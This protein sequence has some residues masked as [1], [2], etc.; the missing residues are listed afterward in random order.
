[1]DNQGNNWTNNQI[2]L[3][4][5]DILNLDPNNYRF[6]DSDNYKSVPESDITSLDVQ[7]RTYKQVIGKNAENIRDLIDSF[8]INGYL[9]VDQIQVKKL[10]NN[11]YLVVEGNRRVAC[12]KYL[13]SKSESEGYDLGRLDK[14]IFS[15]LPVIHY[16]DAADVHHL[17]LMGLKHISGNKKWP[18]INQAEL[19]RT[20][21]THY[22][23]KEDDICHSIGIQ[24]TE[25]NRII[26]TLALIDEYKKSDYGEQF[27][28]EKYS[29]FN[30][31]I[32]SQPIKNW[33]KWNDELRI[34]E[35]KNNLQ[36]LFS[37]ISEEVND[38][39]EDDEE[40]II[41]NNPRYK[42]EPVITRATQIR[43]LA[44]LI[45]ENK[46]LDILDTTRNLSEA[47][48]NSDSLCQIKAKEA[49]STIEKEIN[50]LFCTSRYLSDFDTEKILELNKKL[51][52]VIDVLPK[53]FSS[54]KEFP[55]FFEDC[56]KHFESLF[57]EKFRR[58]QNLRFDNFS[59]INIFAGINNSGK[60][61]VLEAIKFLSSLNSP[62]NLIDLIC[63]RAKQTPNNLDMKWFVDQFSDIS[64]SGIF[65]ELPISLS[66]TNI[67]CPDIE[68]YTYYL[69]SSKFQV[70]IGNNQYKSQT[71]F[72]EK[73][74]PRSNG[75]IISLCPSIF[76]SP[77]S[78]LD[79]ESVVECHSKSLKSNSKSQI[80]DFIQENIDSHIRNIELDNYK[81][82]TVIHDKISPNPDLSLFGEG[83][84][85]IFKIGLLFAYAEN[86]I[87]LIDEFENAIHTSI[88]SKFIALI[89]D[90]AKKFNVQ[91]FLTTHSKE[92]IDAFIE[93]PK[94]DNE[95]I[96]TYALINKDHII[97]VSYFSGEKLAKLKD[98]LD[99]DIRLGN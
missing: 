36:R 51:S 85:R 29:F 52:G 75:Q 40:E 73:Y 86:G 22:S 12:L 6:I 41:S 98:V 97:N 72:Y 92:C 16:T 63:Q 23:L 65:N 56:Q 47:T 88:L 49:I 46:S 78:L 39:I 84:Q 2:S 83:L 80:L 5:V 62:K 81:R 99:F 77:F 79:S 71:H 60:T 18:T 48:L 3:V 13:Q 38:D 9:P 59:R 96:S 11:S 94:V 54:N 45:N 69:K 21:Y 20:L 89:N 87:V 28:P 34:A 93:N 17:I 44:K 35:E 14:N 4:S 68:N 58:L 10:E 27:S 8:R 90:L 31:I 55:L 61:S 91:V 74:L 19:I 76:S 50:A 33:L 66:L 37:W 32:K 43:E 26:R 57:I 30:E 15:Q 1:M 25:F 67:V 42:L 53:D 82:F 7:N 70:S 64:V 24:K 95:Q